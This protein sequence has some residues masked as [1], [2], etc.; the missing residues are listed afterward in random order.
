MMMA[1]LYNNEG[2]LRYYCRVCSIESNGEIHRINN[3]WKM[4]AL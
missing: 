2:K 4:A 3:G 1:F